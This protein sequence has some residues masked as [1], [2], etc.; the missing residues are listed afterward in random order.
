MSLMEEKQVKNTVKDK[1]PGFLKNKWFYAIIILLIIGGYYFQQK[2]ISSQAQEETY[3][4]TQD[5]LQDMLSLSGF[6]DAAEK[7]DLHFQSGGRLSWV[8]V[9]EGDIVEKYDGIASLDQR[10]LQKTI[11]KYL[12]TYSKERRD[13]EQSHDDNEAGVTDMSREIKERAERTLENAQF[14]LNNSVLDVEIQTIVKEY[15]FLYTPVSGIVTRVDAPNAGA[16]VSVTDVYQVINPDSLYFSI[17]ADQTEVVNLYEGMKGKITLDAYP[18]DAMEGVV[19]GISFTPKTNET[20]TVYEVKMEFTPTHSNQ[21]RLG[22]TGDVEFILE[23]IQHAVSVPF[24]HVEEA[25]DGK[26]YVYKR[27]DGKKIKTEITVG[28]EYDGQVQVLDGLYEGDVI[29]EIE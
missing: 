27:I 23:E 12:N 25:E 3:T 17:S 2:N 6:I 11:E 8:G 29:Y 28:S 21:Y 14:D 19:T 10:Q 24:S 20:G 13:F 1:I 18:D 5:T 16:N 26:T 7:A 22:M 15:A 4:V 9:K